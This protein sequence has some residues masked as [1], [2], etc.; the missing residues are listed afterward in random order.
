MARVIPCIHLILYCLKSLTWFYVIVDT[1]YFMIITTLSANGYEAHH[2]QSVIQA[3]ADS[4]APDQPDLPVLSCA[5][6]SVVA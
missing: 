5:A 4:V 1:I 3:Y 2:D 6:L